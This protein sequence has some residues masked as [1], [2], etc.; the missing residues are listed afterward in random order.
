MARYLMMPLNPL[1]LNA[2]D[3]V[4]I[5]VWLIAFN[6]MAKLAVLKGNF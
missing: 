6:K 3:L 5:T 2:R 1:S 4:D